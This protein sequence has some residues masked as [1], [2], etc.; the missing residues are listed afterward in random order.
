MPSSLY[1]FSMHQSYKGAVVSTVSPLKEI[2]MDPHS[3]V[4]AP[5]KRLRKRRHGDLQDHLQRQIGP[6][7]TKIVIPN[8]NLVLN[9]PRINLFMDSI[10]VL[11]GIEPSPLLPPPK[12]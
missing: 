8:L 9:L 10:S 7:V 3:Q 6:I 12:V 1:L 4:L 11:N 2:Q 5:F